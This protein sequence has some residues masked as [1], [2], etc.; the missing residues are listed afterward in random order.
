MCEHVKVFPYLLYTSA[1]NALCFEHCC[2]QSAV[3]AVDAGQPAHWVDQAAFGPEKPKQFHGHGLPE[4]CT[5]THNL[6]H[7][8][9][10]V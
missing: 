7:I 8:H 9:P 5:N 3:E 1:Q 4:N 6:L 10:L 2:V